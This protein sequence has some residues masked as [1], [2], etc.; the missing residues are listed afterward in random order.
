MNS[1]RVIN[2]GIIGTGVGLRTHLPG[3]LKTGRARVVAIAGSNQQRAEGFA[4]KYSIPKAF[5]DYRK[6]CNLPE[7]DLVCVASPNRFHFDHVSTAIKVRKH[8]LAEKP[9]AMSLKETLKLRDLAKRY[10]NQLI[11]VDHQLRFNP[12]FQ[13]IKELI[14]TQIGRAY[15]VRIHQQ[16]TGFSNPDAPWIWSFDENEGGGV[17]LAMGSH[18]IDLVRFWFEGRNIYNVNGRM[19]VV[20]PERKDSRGKK[21]KVG[22]SGFYAA[23]LSMEGGLEINMSA[24]AAAIGESRFDISVYGTQGE[25]HFDLKNKLSAAFMPNRMYS[26]I[27]VNGVTEEE[28][29]NKI[30]FFAGSFIYYA[31]LIVS[32]LLDG[33]KTTDFST[34]EDAI[35]TQ[36]IL[37]AVAKSA[38]SGKTLVLKR[39][40]TPLSKI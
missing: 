38:S 15:F 29:A 25:L 26:Q 34:F 24:T 16:S 9:L 22:A 6:L 23:N 21:R 37:D 12:Y 2:V 35:H 30:S 14:S 7:V 17:R 13:K 10:S 40:Y 5:G 18:L 32:A 1:D 8:V 31:P 33:T 28:L 20:I 36:I 11:L 19:D 39:G 27:P 3:F 4:Q